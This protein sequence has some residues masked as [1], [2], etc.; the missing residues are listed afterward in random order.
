[1]GKQIRNNK[2]KK[3]TVFKI[4]FREDFSSFLLRE[5]GLSCPW[6]TEGK[7][8]REVCVGNCSH[9]LTPST[10]EW[11]SPT[12]RRTKCH[13]TLDYFPPECTVWKKCANKFCIFCRL[14]NVVL[15]FL[16]GFESFDLFHM[17]GERNEAK[18][19]MQGEN[20]DFFFC[21]GCGC[22]NADCSPKQ[23]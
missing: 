8:G 22:I 21:G 1:M 17:E 3:K 4:V 9:I 16:G 18:E 10:K 7:R 12:H 2:T 15:S 11:E 13:I 14:V 23:N 20:R 19:N 5:I 6:T